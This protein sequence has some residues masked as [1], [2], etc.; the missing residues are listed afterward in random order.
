MLKQP[1]ESTGTTHITSIANPLG[2]KPKKHPPTLI[3]FQK[4]DHFSI[5][6]GCFL[7]CYSKKIYIIC[8]FSTSYHTRPNDKSFMPRGLEPDE[9]WSGRTP[10][11]P[12]RCMSVCPPYYTASTLKTSPTDRMEN[13]PR[14]CTLKYFHSHS[15]D[16]ERDWKK[17]TPA[18]AF[19]PT[20]TQ[21]GTI[22]CTST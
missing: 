4:T 15:A 12:S 7:C 1:H 16:H 3:F 18:G 14:H 6:Q 21:Q 20:S 8:F 9:G 5:W 11:R 17:K 2:A 10:L 13:K 22:R 19:L